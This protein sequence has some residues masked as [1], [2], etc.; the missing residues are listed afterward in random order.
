M[1][2]NWFD[3]K[4]AQE[5]GKSL[6]EKFSVAY[7]AIDQKKESASGNKEGLRAKVQE[8]QKKVLGRL[9][10]E[11][12]QFAKSH[13]LNVYKKAKLGNAFKWVLIE[14]GYEAQFVDELTKEVIL[15]LK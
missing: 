1:L 8:K 10:L 15:A 7:P 6:A 3:A 11:V 2:K 13:R 14:K 5:F 9:T 12:N 4:E